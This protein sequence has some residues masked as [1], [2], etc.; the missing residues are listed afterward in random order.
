MN[1]R[2]K[3]QHEEFIVVRNS[4]LDLSSYP[5]IKVRNRKEH[6]EE[7]IVI[8]AS[9]WKT[10][11]GKL[12]GALKAFT[13]ICHL[14]GE[15]LLKVFVW[16]V[17]VGIL[18]RQH[19]EVLKLSS[20][21]LWALLAL[22]IFLFGSIGRA[23]FKWSELVDSWLNPGIRRYVVER[24]EP[25]VTRSLGEWC[26]LITTYFVALSIAA[27]LTWFVILPALEAIVPFVLQLMIEFVKGAA[28]EGNT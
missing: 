24:P 23:L 18:V 17:L 1:E 14:F 15:W 9:R 3:E 21:A 20:P 2:P 13:I 19:G 4:D 22:S 6:D 8:G 28:Y 12:K 10:I 11:F 26:I 7:V 25:R 16:L 5:E 27:G